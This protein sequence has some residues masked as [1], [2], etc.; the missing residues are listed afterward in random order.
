MVSLTSL[1]LIIARVV[2][3]LIKQIGG[4]FAPAPLCFTIRFLPL[5][6]RP[7]Q[8]TLTHVP[9]LH[10]N[11]PLFH[12]MHLSTCTMCQ[13]QNIG[14]YILDKRSSIYLQ[15]PHF[16]FDFSFLVLLGYDGSFSTW[17]RQFFLSLF[18]PLPSMESFTQRFSQLSRTLRL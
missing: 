4:F 2:T 7:T 9:T 16:L 3:V 10:S 5:R 14:S 15:P 13:N 1:L 11:I 6:F 12:A 8:S 18:S 17:Y